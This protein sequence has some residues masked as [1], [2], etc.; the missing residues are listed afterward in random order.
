MDGLGDELFTE[1]R[2]SD[3]SIDSG[4]DSSN[5]PSQ[6]VLQPAS[7]TRRD[8]S[9]VT[10]EYSSDSIHFKD[11]LLSVKDGGQL[12]SLLDGLTKKE[13]KSGSAYTWKRIFDF[14]HQ[15]ARICC[16]RRDEKSNGW[17]KL[18]QIFCGTHKQFCEIPL[19]ERPS[20]M[21]CSL[22]SML[23]LSL[24]QTSK[25]QFEA[26]PHLLWKILM[27][28]MTKKPAHRS[29]MSHFRSDYALLIDWLLSL[30]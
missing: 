20:Q 13:Y 7:P 22:A 15:R 21:I 23:Y 24:P 18:Q 4:F 27:S 28:V 11:C 25:G 26:L 29:T 1:V 2:D 8:E 17:Q 12:L 10:M 6:M 30:T 14:S 3:S 19:Q 5:L 9:E 16:S